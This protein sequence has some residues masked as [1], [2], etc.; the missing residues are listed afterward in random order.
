MKCKFQTRLFQPIILFFIGIIHCAIFTLLLIN[1]LKNFDP[2]S[3]AGVLFIVIYILTIM[4]YI[5]VIAYLFQW[6]EYENNIL[7]FRCVF[8]VFKE[9]KVEDIKSFEIIEIVEKSPQRT[10]KEKVIIVKDRNSNESKYKYL[11][12]RKTSYG[13]IYYTEKNLKRLKEILD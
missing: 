2:F 1:I 13:V 5:L 10:I 12:N 4:C 7:R 6:A 3:S 8:Y 11:M 9:I